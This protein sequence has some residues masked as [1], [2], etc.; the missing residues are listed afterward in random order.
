MGLDLLDAS[1]SQAE[2]NR[3]LAT[4]AV[5]H[6]L[7]H[8]LGFD[9]NLFD[10]WVDVTAS[11][12]I[13]SGGAYVNTPVSNNGGLW[14]LAYASLKTPSV[15][16]AARAHYSCGSINEGE[17]EVK[18]KQINRKTNNRTEQNRTE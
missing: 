17:M 2:S 1:D 3:T 6:D 11:Y 8:G 12:S 9:N 4:L 10:D 5:L 7:I 16:L 18:N 14:D 15:L 13:Y